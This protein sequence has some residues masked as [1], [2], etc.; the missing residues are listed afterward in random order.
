MGPQ[1]CIVTGSI[2]R[3]LRLA[4]LVVAIVA[5]WLAH[6]AVEAAAQGASPLVAQAQPA[7][8]ESVSVRLNWF[9]SG[10]TAP[11]YVGVDKGWYREAGLDVTVQE[12]QG[13]GPTAQQVAAGRSTFGFISADALIRAVAQGAPLKMVAALAETNGYCVLVKADSGIKSAKDLEGKRYGAGAASSIA[14]LLPAY[15]KAG[16]ADIEKVQRLSVDPAN[17]YAGFLGGRYEAMEAL[18]FDEPPRFD[19]RGTKTA[20]LP[21][22]DSG[23]RILGPGVV[24]SL[25]TLQEKPDVVKRFL[26]V[27]LRAFT[28]GYQHPDEAAATVK[29]MAGESVADQGVSVAQLKLFEKLQ[30][31][32]FGAMNAGDWQKSVA[33]MK[34]Y[35]ELQNAPSDM[36]RLFTNEFLP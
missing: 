7:A 33:I 14:R 10:Y 34:E 31:K 8:V 9:A 30:G 22:A 19:A 36:A 18:S 16:N 5:G 3:H 25:S 27:T 35:L 29:K 1:R 32:P 13:S 23:V 21:Y 12:G 6:A 15:M 24:T 20:C 11:F 17:L 28:Y 4:G 26:A 2:A